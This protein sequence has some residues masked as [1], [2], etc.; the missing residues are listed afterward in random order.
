MERVC[1][2]ATMRACVCRERVA[3]SCAA[4]NQCLLLL[5]DIYLYVYYCCEKNKTKNYAILPSLAA[6]SAP[7][8]ITMPQPQATS[9]QA[10]IRKLKPTP[11]SFSTYSCQ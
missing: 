5:S 3:N 8:S 1:M 9:Q 2:Y 6:P 10:S 7:S 4:V 11:V